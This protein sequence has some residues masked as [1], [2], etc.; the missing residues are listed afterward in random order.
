MIVYMDSRVFGELYLDNEKDPEIL[1]AQYVVVS[2]RIRRKT[3]ENG[4]KWQNITIQSMQL[5]PNQNC[6][7]AYDTDEFMHEYYHQL[8]E[9]KGFLAYLVNAVAK[10][11]SIN[12]VLISSEREEKHFNC[13]KIIA[14]YIWDTFKFPV[15]NYALYVYGCDI[16]EYDEEKVIKRTNKVLEEMVK[17]RRR[18]FKVSGDYNRLL[19]EYERMSTK[20]LRKL[21]KKE[22]LYEDS[23]SR[24][25]MLEV[26]Q[27]F[28]M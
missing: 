26:I 3:S 18:T 16:Q 7:N 12:V 21:L 14:Q 25:D 22:E 1:K 8:D 9:H 15:Y 4:D 28:L 23:M 20:E 11:P 24:D 5:F 6:M 2:T 17:E 27:T 10:D 13:L 19:K